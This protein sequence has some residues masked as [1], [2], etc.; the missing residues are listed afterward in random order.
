MTIYKQSLILRSCNYGKR[1]KMLNCLA[2]NFKKS[3]S[4]FIY[5]YQTWDQFF[6]VPKDENLFF[7][8]T[9]TERCE[10]N[11]YVCFLPNSSRK[12]SRFGVPVDSFSL[13]YPHLFMKKYKFIFK[14]D[15]NW[16]WR[17]RR[18]FHCEK[19]FPKPSF[20]VE[21]VEIVK[22]FVVCTSRTSIY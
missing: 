4:S 5:V 7:V 14:G 19:F 11:W 22:I 6:L 2:L 9:G 17:W 18:S 10:R 15:C 3:D 1:L 12:V 8:N 16:S 13:E 21:S 20:G